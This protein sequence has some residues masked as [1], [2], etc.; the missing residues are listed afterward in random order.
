MC[1]G[2]RARR[3]TM[4]PGTAPAGECPALV[5]TNNAIIGQGRARQ[6]DGPAA[7]VLRGHRLR[8]GVLIDGWACG[9]LT[10]GTTRRALRARSRVGPQQGHRVVDGVPLRP[11]RGCQPGRAVRAPGGVV[12]GAGLPVA[13]VPAATR[14]GRVTGNGPAAVFWMTAFDRDCLGCLVAAS[15]ARPGARG[16]FQFPRHRSHGL[17]TSSRAC[18][19]AAVGP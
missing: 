1:S 7:S 8:A 5:S 3:G 18:G 14:T 19:C 9:F 6:G 2:P 11:G 16:C 17:P 15:P 10:G 12:P 4:A 13:L